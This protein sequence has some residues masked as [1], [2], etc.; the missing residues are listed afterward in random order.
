MGVTWFIDDLGWNRNPLS[1]TLSIFG[2]GLFQPVLAHLA[3]AF[4]DGRLRSHLDR[5]LVMATY[6]A[7]VLV[8]FARMSF[9]DPGPGL[10]R[11]LLMIRSDARLEAVADRGGVVVVVVL[12]ALVAAMLFWHWWTASAL[13]RRALAPVIWSSAPVTYLIVTTTLMGRSGSPPLAQLALTALPAGFLIG[14]LRIRLARARVTK[15]VIELSG[16]PPRR[17]L[18]DALARTLRDPS[19]EVAYWL[20]EGRYFADVAGTR[21]D[22]PEG[23]SRLPIASQRDLEPLGMIVHDPALQEDP[24]LIEAATA[25]ARLVIENERLHAEVKAQLQTG[26]TELTRTEQHLPASSQQRYGLTPREREVLTLIAKGCSNQAI[27]ERLSLSSK[28]VETH[29]RSIFTKLELPV[30]DRDHRRVLAVL[31]YLRDLDR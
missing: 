14:L 16:M 10:P 17:G 30:T 7:Y 22:L 25:A 5:A 18:R 27:C 19:L 15:L 12:T 11:N 1:Y 24:E 9:W 2:R 20:R 13:G 31:T 28:T 21:L 29:V 3:L 6:V 8:R 23:P 26:E 4:P